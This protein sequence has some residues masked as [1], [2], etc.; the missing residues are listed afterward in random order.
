MTRLSKAL[1]AM[2]YQYCDWNV[3]S[4]DAGGTISTEEVVSNVISGIQSHSVSVVLQ[5]DIKGFS[6]D[7]VEQ[8]VAWGLANGYTFLPMDSTTPMVHQTI[9]N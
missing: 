1:T 7:A 4:G 9:S 8:I 6:V 2:G 5:H 3:T